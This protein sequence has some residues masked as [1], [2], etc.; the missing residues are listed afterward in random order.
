[1]EVWKKKVNTQEG[2]TEWMAIFNGHVDARNNGRHVEKSMVIKSVDAQTTSSGRCLGNFWPKEEFESY[3]KRLLDA[4]ECTW[5]E[6]ENGSQLF[7]ILRFTYLDAAP[8]MLPPAVFQ[9]YKK[10]AS[11]IKRE[12]E[13]DH[14]VKHIRNGEG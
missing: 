14:G 13:E 1:M 3:H 9:L 8:H 11:G 7:G 2:L 10:R 6:D 4:S 12:R 5:E